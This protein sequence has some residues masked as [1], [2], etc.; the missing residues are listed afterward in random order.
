MTNNTVE[1]LTFNEVTEKYNTSLEEATNY[2]FFVRDINLQNGQIAKLKSFKEN[3]KRF[4]AQ[5][6][7][8]KNEQTTNIF[9]HFQCVLNS[10]I[11]VLEMWASLKQN[12]NFDAWVKLIDAQE[13]L[14]IALRIN[15]GKPFGVDGFREHLEHIEKAVFPR[16]S[17]FNSPAFIIKGGVCSIC[18]QNLARCEHVEDKIY[19][20]KVC[21]RIKAEVIETNHLAVVENPKDKRCIIT[22]IT[23]DDN[24]Y[25]DCFT[26]LK[27]EPVENPNSKEHRF[28]GMFFSTQFLDIF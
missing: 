12:K 9:F 6:I 7:E 26:W 5:A 1:T 8:R 3:I 20:G 4:K 27:T 24:Y 23:A 16:F 17:I 10:Y 28:K 15:I 19:W 25:Q 11:S 22:E 18:G 14:S 21:K 13:Y 2:V